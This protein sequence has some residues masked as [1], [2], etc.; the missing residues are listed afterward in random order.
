MGVASHEGSEEQEPLQPRQ[1]SRAAEPPQPARTRRFGWLGAVLQLPG[2]VINVGLQ[3][4]GQ[5]LGLG[6]RLVQAVSS[7][8]LPR[9]VTRALQG[10]R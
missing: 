9:S 7:I 6:A 1:A 4:L 8:L 2:A 10:R 5:V 3:T